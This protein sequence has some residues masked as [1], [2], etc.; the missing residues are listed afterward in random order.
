MREGS[1]RGARWLLCSAV[2]GIGRGAIRSPLQGSDVFAWQPQGAALGC[3]RPSRWDS[4]PRSSRTTKSS[5]FAITATQSDA[6]L[7]TATRGT[8]LRTK[9]QERRT[10]NKER[11]AS[12]QQLQTTAND[13]QRLQTTANFFFLLLR[14]WCSVSSYFRR[15]RCI[16][17]TALGLLP[18]RTLKP[19]DSI[20]L[21]TCSK[22]SPMRFS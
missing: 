11:S 1:S 9:H 18:W 7:E 8:R 5:F 17:T 16:C 20:T 15:F 14:A 12:S 6:A 3:D 2:P 22:V 19:P 21:L 4:K 10:K 13:C